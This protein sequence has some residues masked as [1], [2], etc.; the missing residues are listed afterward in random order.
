MSR[1]RA[2]DT[3][4]RVYYMSTSRVNMASWLTLMVSSTLFLHLNVKAPPTETDVSQHFNGETV[5]NIKK[6]KRTEHNRRQ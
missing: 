3:L 1:S 2:S 5:R 4:V 6:Y